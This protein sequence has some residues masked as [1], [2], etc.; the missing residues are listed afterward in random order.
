MVR[1]LKKHKR[2]LY[3]IYPV[4]STSRTRVKRAL[5]MASSSTSTGANVESRACNPRKRT[6]G[7]GL[8]KTSSSPLS[9]HAWVCRIRL[10]HHDPSL[11][12]MLR[13]KAIIIHVA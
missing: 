6:R 3:C 2:Q 9:P 5:A 13:P 4:A 10:H 7:N 11:W 8:F 12:L 1:S